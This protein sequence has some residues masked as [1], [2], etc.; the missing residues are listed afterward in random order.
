MA[1]DLAGRD[2]ESIHDILANWR[3]LVENEREKVM[4]WL[5]DRKIGWRGCKM[6]VG[7]VIGRPGR[8]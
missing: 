1:W 4:W 8:A 3:W 5:R 7:K 6:G 2:Q